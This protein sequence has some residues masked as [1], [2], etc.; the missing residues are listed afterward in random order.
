MGAQVVGRAFAR[1]LQ[2]EYAGMSLKHPLIFSSSCNISIIFA[3]PF[4]NAPF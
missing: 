4:I 2:Q 1:A 3:L